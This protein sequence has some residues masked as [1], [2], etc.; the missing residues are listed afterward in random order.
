[1]LEEQLLHVVAHRLGGGLAGDRDRLHRTTLGDEAQQLLVLRGQPAVVG[2][3]L[4]QPVDDHRVEG[5]AAGRHGADRLHE[6]VA[7][8]DAVLQ[9]VGVAGR[10]LAEERDGVLGVVVLGEHDDAGARV[11]PAHLL[12]RLDALALEARGHAD[13]GD[14]DLGGGRDGTGEEL[15]VVGGDADDLEVLLAVRGGP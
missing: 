15:V 5:G 11:V 2:D 4:H 12:R 8:G 9:L 10:A 6:L 14:D 1:M 13:V 7:L 3:R